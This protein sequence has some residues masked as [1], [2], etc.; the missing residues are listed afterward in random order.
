M[1]DYLLDSVLSYDTFMSILMFI[2]RKS[3]S[4]APAYSS[5]IFASLGDFSFQSQETSVRLMFTTRSASVFTLD[6]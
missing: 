1:S 2:F 5:F 3:A 4:N 6:H